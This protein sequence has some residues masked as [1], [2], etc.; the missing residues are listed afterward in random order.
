MKKTPFWHKYRKTK[1][2]KLIAAAPLFPE[3]SAA[4]RGSAT[5]Q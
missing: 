2:A 1:P 3:V 5:A 4:A